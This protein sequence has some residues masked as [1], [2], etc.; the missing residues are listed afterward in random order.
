MS[1]TPLREGGGT[2]MR[3]AGEEP[4]IQLRSRLPAPAR[5]ALKTASSLSNRLSPASSE[6]A[7][8]ACQLDVIMATSAG[9]GVAREE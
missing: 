6:A 7:L 3:G 1:S 8:A 4:T 9:S 2:R 5:S